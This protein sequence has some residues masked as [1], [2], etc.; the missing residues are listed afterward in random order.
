LSKLG[1]FGEWIKGNYSDDN[2]NENELEGIPLNFA[3]Y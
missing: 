2:S 3:N 1:N